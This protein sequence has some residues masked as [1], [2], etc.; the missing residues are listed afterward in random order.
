MPFITKNGKPV[1]I[2]PQRDT[3]IDWV[4]RKKVNSDTIKGVKIP[5]YILH[6]KDDYMKTLPFGFSTEKEKIEH[7]KEY[8]D[9]QKIRLKYDIRNEE[10]RAIDDYH[11]MYLDSWL[12]HNKK[13]EDIQIELSVNKKH[14]FHG[15][16][17]DKNRERK[18]EYE[19]K[20]LKDYQDRLDKL[21]KERKL[22]YD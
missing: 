6:G 2:T 12:A 1:W 11:S 16:V 17:W 15:K 21:K 13:K 14:N 4:T 8:R 3:D 18:L 5:D 20:Q 7:E 19:E 10:I 22:Y 9:E